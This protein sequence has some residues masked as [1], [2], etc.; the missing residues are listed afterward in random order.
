MDRISYK[1]KI[2]TYLRLL[3]KLNIKAGLP[4]IGWRD[5]VESK[6][7]QETLRRGSHFSFATDAELVEI[8][9]KVGRQEEELL[10]R[11]KLAKSLTTPHA[12]PHKRKPEEADT[13]LNTT[14]QKRGSNNKAGKGPS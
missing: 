5:C 3:E 2:D 1:W 6:L 12:A 9:R 7:A 8:L 13:G 4:G 14:Y 11:G 10:E